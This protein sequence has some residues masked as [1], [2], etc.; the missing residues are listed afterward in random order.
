[1][2]TVDAFGYR[3]K[4]ETEKDDWITLVIHFNLFKTE[5]NSFF[6]KAK[7][8]NLKD[9]DFPKRIGLEVQPAA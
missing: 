4:K 8:E 5:K 7:M 2:Q 6:V 1:M 3:W 9:K